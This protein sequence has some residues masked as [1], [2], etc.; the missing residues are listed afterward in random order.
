MPLVVSLVADSDDDTIFLETSSGEIKVS[1][2]QSKGGKVRLLV[3]CPRDVP[4]HRA[5]VRRARAIEHFLRLIEGA[6]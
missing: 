4:V 6:D 2:I 3:D 1:V 5:K